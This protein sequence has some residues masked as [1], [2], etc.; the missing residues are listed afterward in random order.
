MATR[1]DD[2]DRT[3][4]VRTY[5]EVLLLSVL[6]AVFARTFL[7]Q[8]IAIPT[9]S[10]ADSLLPGDRVLVNRFALNGLDTGDSRWLPQRGVR[11]GDVVVFAHPRDARRTFV[12]RCVGTPGDTVELVDK[13]LIVNGIEVDDQRYASRR[14]PRTFTGSTTRDRRRLGRDNFGPYTVPAGHYFVLG[15]NRDHSDD[16]RFWGPVP[17]STIK[18]RAWLVYWS[19]D[20]VRLPAADHGRIVERLDRLMG[21]LRATRW[22]RSAR[23]VR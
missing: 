20:D 2:T 19:S 11:R 3:T 12:K 21:T 10:M 23:I 7:L 15:D 5:L 18:G 4:T 9:A 6:L 22:R 17:H 16:S 13:Q 1:H 8:V 14:D